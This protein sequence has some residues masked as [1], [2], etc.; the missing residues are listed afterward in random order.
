VKI[1][2]IR[3]GG[4]YLNN[5]VFEL[6]TPRALLFLLD[7]N[8]H[9]NLDKSVRYTHLERNGFPVLVVYPYVPPVLVICQLL[10]VRHR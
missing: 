6:C 1:L 9:R 10:L 2:L 3:E 8:A 4:L 5:C 7:F